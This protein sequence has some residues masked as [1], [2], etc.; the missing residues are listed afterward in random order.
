MRHQES[1][2]QQAIIKHF[3]TYYPKLN[4]LLFSCPNGAYLSGNIKR[5]ATLKREG[6]LAGVSDLILL[7]PNKQYHALCIEVKTE[8]GRQSETQ[9]AFEKKVTEQGYK[10]AIVKS[11]FEFNQ[12]LTNYLKNE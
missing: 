6:L 3:A 11:V 1:K 9:K 4:G 8:K 5:A 2:I 10:Y 12:L 7:I